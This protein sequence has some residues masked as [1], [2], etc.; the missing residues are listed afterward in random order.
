MPSYIYI[1]NV[2]LC[3]HGEFCF[4]SFNNSNDDCNENN[5]ERN[6]TVSLYSYILGTF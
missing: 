1:P 3:V 5:V 2:S 6:F 4:D